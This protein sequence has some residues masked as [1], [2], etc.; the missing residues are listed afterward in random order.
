[1]HEVIFF[2]KGVRVM[3]Q[4]Y[5]LRTDKWVIICMHY[6]VPD[7]AMNISLWLYTLKNKVF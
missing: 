4:K 7:P 5:G 3:H 2:P 1:M 6:T